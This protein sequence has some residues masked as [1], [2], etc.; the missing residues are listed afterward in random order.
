MQPF[1]HMYTLTLT[2][3]H[4]HSHTQTETHTHTQYYTRVYR[5]GTYRLIHVH[6][7][8]YGHKGIHAHTGALTL[9]IIHS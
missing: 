8:M 6:T 5:A 9:H 1:A 3:T 4:T 2:Y 7:L